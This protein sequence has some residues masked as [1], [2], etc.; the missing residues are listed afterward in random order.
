M[1]KVFTRQ[2]GKPSSPQEKPVPPKCLIVYL[3]INH[4]QMMVSFNKVLGANIKDADVKQI[5]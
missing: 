3:L 5:Q 4:L 2:C 1:L